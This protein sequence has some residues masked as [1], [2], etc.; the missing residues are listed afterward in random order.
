[1]YYLPLALA[2]DI[3]IEWPITLLISDSYRGSGKVS[4]EIILL[5][6][7]CRELEGI[8]PMLSSLKRSLSPELMY[9]PFGILLPRRAK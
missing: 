2:L 1:M 7:D 4:R 6:R 9:S 8:S 5:S 3:F